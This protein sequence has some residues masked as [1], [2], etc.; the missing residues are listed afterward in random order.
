MLAWHAAPG[1]LGGSR[2][3]K[4]FPWKQKLSFDNL[5]KLGN[6]VL[7]L[8]VNRTSLEDENFAVL[9][10]YFA[11]VYAYDLLRKHPRMGD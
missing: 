9:C 2:G 6:Q 4:Y 3:H 8:P 1:A 10:R 11:E 5:S 7:P